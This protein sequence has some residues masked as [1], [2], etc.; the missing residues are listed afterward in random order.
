[1]RFQEEAC[2]N[3]GQDLTAAEAVRGREMPQAG[4]MVF[5][6][7]CPGCGTNRIM[8]PPVAEGPVAAEAPET[9]GGGEEEEAAGEDDEPAPAVEAEATPTEA[10]PTEEAEAT[11][12]EAGPTEEA[13]SP[14]EPD[15]TVCP[16]C[17]GAKSPSANVCRNCYEAGQSQPE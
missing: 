3:C 15:P 13:M 11:A 1:M 9:G 4:E 12:T 16:K 2:G 8:V 10:G 6:G 7:A 14:T 17:G 5:L